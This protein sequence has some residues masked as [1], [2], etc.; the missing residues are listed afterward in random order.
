MEKGIDRSN[1]FGNTLKVGWF[2]A[3]RQIKGSNKATTLLIIFIMMLTFLNL[4]VVSGILVGLIEGGNIANREQYTG[5][6]I[7][8]TLPGEK[9]IG[10]TYEI[11][12]TL[13]KMSGV[14]YF[15]VRYFEG[16]QIEANYKTRRDFD[17]LQDLVSTQITGINIKNEEELSNISD[18]IV[19]GEFLK[20]G[21]SG[22]IIMG[23]SLLRRYSA[24]FGDYFASLE[25][26][27]P[28][29]EVKVTVGDNTRTFIV[30][31][32]LDSKV[33]EVSLRAF[34]TEEDFW[35]LSDRPGLNG[36]EIS[37]SI[38]PGATLTSTEL[39]SNLIKAGFENQ[40]KIQTALEAIPDFLNQIK[41]AFS[42]LGNVIGL[43]GIAVASITIFIVIFINAV[44][45]RKY[46]GIMKGIGISERAIEISYIFQSIFYATLGGLLGLLLV[47]GGLVPL[48]LAHP[49]DFPFSDGI[50]VAPV[51]DTTF[52][53]F[54]LLLV[55]L[56]AGYI[57][58]RRIVKKNT[59]DSILGR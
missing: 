8:K 19:E 57:P 29:E 11:T 21:E 2:L 26:V 23:S 44:T 25:G 30:K 7:I 42:L 58:A 20:E 10:K 14:E 39:K 12:N 53:F 17:T 45:R 5:D 50:L 47:Y 22:Y 49:L 27:Y 16:G 54:L 40:G 9:D 48:F 15:S 59:L 52:K 56:I 6:V 13:E 37:I 24:D 4:V 34:I 38:I 28:G 1:K 43:I 55:T 36:N 41:I 33:G 18:Y 35:R 3:K 46:I 32:I 51:P 31:G